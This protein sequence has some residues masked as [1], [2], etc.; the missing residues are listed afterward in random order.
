MSVVPLPQ[1][2]VS[3]QNTPQQRRH[4]CYWMECNQ[5]FPNMME[6]QLHLKDLHIELLDKGLSSF[7]CHWKDCDE[8]GFESKHKLIQHIQEKHFHLSN[9]LSVK[10]KDI[11]NLDETHTNGKLTDSRPVQLR[12]ELNYNSNNIQR[13]NEPSN[14]VKEV[15]FI[16]DDDPESNNNSAKNRVISSE[17][18]RPQVLDNH[19]S[20]DGD[21]SQEVISPNMTSSPKID[22]S[23]SNKTGLSTS[24]HLMKIPEE[25]SQLSSN[26]LN[27]V[28]QPSISKQLFRAVYSYNTTSDQNNPETSMQ[29]IL[30]VKN[31]QENSI[32]SPLQTESDQS[33]SSVPFESLPVD[34]QNEKLRL[35]VSRQEREIKKL[36][37]KNALQEK[38]LEQTEAELEIQT[39]ISKLLQDQNRRA[40]DKLR[41]M[42]SNMLC[43][44][45]H[46]RDEEHMTARSA[47]RQK[48]EHT[49]T[50]DNDEKQMEIDSWEQPLTDSTI[51][52]VTQAFVC[53]WGGCGKVFRTKMAL[54]AHIPSE[55]LGG[56]ILRV[57]VD[58]IIPNTAT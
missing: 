26:L 16:E 42:W 23:G 37:S 32:R 18:S 14:S 1:H 7:Q 38:Q 50:K 39:R 25:K 4:V 35:L 9:T 22:T 10:K 6:I 40:D 24:S 21:I 48:Q 13:P 12:D 54:K 19:S 57:K 8:I 44:K 28:P 27:I 34:Q 17:I 49:N 31:N 15:I 33:P 5:P 47:K 53:E 52:I 20:N 43:K 55:H 30:T 41:S 51:S 29:E 56:T 58:R 3:Q 46:M 2:T 45:V 36:K 11:N